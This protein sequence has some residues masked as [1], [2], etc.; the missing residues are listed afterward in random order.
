[1]SLFSFFRKLSPED[2]YDEL[3]LKIISLSLMFPGSVNFIQEIDTTNVQKAN[4]GIEIAYL[5]L[6][7][8]DRQAFKILGPIGRDKVIDEVAK[9]VLS[10]Y[11]KTVLRKDTPLTLMQDWA[12]HKLSTFNERTIL[13]HKCK[14]VL[15]EENPWASGTMVF[16]L[17]FYIH[18]ALGRTDRDDV[19][20]ILCGE[21]NL[22]KSDMRDFPVWHQQS[23]IFIYF[24]SV[25]A[26]WKINKTL[27]QL[28]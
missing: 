4:S 20:D 6:H 22:E 11:C 27:K 25:L 13:Y 18:K 7:I 19:D 21:R 23:E 8:L 14:S 16:A 17:S 24:S 5:L 2:I 12:C 26:E 28:K 9:R 10:R 15:G 3:S 1:M